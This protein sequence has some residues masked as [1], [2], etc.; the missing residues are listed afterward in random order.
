MNRP[1]TCINL[2]KAINRIAGPERDAL[3]LG[4]ALANV[5][6]AQMLPDGVVK[7]GSSL[8]FRKER[9][10]RKGRLSLP[11]NSSPHLCVLCDLCGSHFQF[12]IPYGEN[13]AKWHI[14]LWGATFWPWRIRRR[15]GS[16]GE[17]SQV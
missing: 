15:Y 2:I 10:D 6:I 16:G 3:R 12:P 7:G 17:V 14:A 8:M 13:R 9:K 4:R 1:N 11:P 5:I